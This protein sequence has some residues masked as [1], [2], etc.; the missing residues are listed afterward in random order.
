M[1][2]PVLFLPSAL[3]FTTHRINK[4]QHVHR[5]TTLNL[6]GIFYGTSTGSTE[7]AAQLIA[8][9]LG[10]DAAGPFEIDVSVD[11]QFVWTF[12]PIL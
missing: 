6:I 1:R 8:K 11:V 4:K 9:E 5:S 3:A 12:D 7:E 10:D 2:S